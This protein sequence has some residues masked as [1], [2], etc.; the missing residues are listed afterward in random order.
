MNS[1]WQKVKVKIKKD[2]Q[3]E[4]C[5]HI[6]IYDLNMLVGQFEKVTA[7]WKVKYVGTKEQLSKGNKSK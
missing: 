7:E 6:R 3:T 4:L 5:V 1:K 2:L